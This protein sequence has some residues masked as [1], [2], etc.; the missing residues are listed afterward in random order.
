MI[1][2]F[3][4]LLLSA[5]DVLFGWA[6]RRSPD[7]AVIVIALLSA[8]ILVALRFFTTEQNLLERCRADKRR[9]NV[10]IRESK[11]RKDKTERLRLRQLKA[12]V[13]LKQLRAEIRPLLWA[14]L[15]VALLGIWAWQRLEFLGLKPHQPFQ[16]TA[17]FPLGTSSKVA[18]LVPLK[19]VQS[20]QGWIREIKPAEDSHSPHAQASWILTA[21]DAVHLPL[22]L[23]L[24]EQT[25]AHDL[26]ADGWRYTRPT[27][28]HPGSEIT[29]AVV[30]RRYHAFGIIPN[31][32]GL[33][34]SWVT[35]YFLIA[36][37]AMSAGKRLW[38]VR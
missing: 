22:S 14:V 34:P 7:F 27:V 30:L 32:A 5:G 10:L 4:H 36:I 6:A 23:R 19:S 9:L 26:V 11:R 13:G 12:A 15:P 20:E 16:F 2:M 8:A 3:N 1:E 18:Y 28:Q 33:W 24:G 17:T 38:K 21:R 25:F 29:T 35:A 31:I 37:P